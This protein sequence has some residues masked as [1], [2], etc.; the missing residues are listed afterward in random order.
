[1]RRI[2]QIAVFMISVMLMMSSCK[3]DEKAPEP[4]VTTTPTPNPT[5]TA[6]WSDHNIPT[7]FNVFYRIAFINDNDGFAIGSDATLPP[8]SNGYIYKTTDAA[9]A[10]SCSGAAPG[11]AAYRRT[12]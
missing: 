2:K 3:K 12:R 8:S 5:P 10:A 11:T 7:P 6:Q 4:E 9:P 1:M